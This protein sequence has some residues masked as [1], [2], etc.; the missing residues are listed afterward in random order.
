ML[1]A[2]LII[3]ST[4][5]SLVWRP[6]TTEPPRGHQLPPCNSSPTYPIE[7]NDKDDT[8]GGGLGAPDGRIKGA[9][10]LGPLVHSSEV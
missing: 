7:Q 8:E 2:P 9:P 4:H 3:S 1:G 5:S 10:L 6:P